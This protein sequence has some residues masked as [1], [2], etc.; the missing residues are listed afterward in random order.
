M[1]KFNEKYEGETAVINDPIFVIEGV[2]RLTEWLWLEENPKLKQ[3]TKVAIDV[4]LEHL[5]RLI[6]EGGE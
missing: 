6:Q 4:L 1:P 3:D 2:R 5:K